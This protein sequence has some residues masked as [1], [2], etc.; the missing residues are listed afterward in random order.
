MWHTFFCYLCPASI[1]EVTA[2][3]KRCHYPFILRG[4]SRWP[5]CTWVGI[6]LLLLLTACRKEVDSDVPIGHFPAAAICDSLYQ[7]GRNHQ[8]LK[9]Y[10]QAIDCFRRCLSV[11]AAALDSLELV[12]LQKPLT[13]AMV[14]LV[15]TYQT[16][17]HPEAC[18]AYLD[19]L[20]VSSSPVI[21]A[22]FLRD[23]LSV[24]AYALSRT[25]RMDEAEQYVTRALQ[26][27]LWHPSE[28]RLFRDYA[29]AAAVY[30][31]NP[32][33]EEEVILYCRQA[34]ELAQFSHNLSGQQYVLS[35]LGTLFKRTGRI[36]EAID[37]LEQSIEVSRR[38]DDPLGEINAYNALTELLLYW[39][40]PQQAD[41]FASRGVVLARNLQRQVHR[42]ANPVILGQLY[43]GK[44]MVK[45]EMQ[46]YDSAFYYYRLSE[47]QVSELPYNSG[48]A[49]VDLSIGEM[50]GD[51]PQ[52]TLL[53]EGRFRLQRAATE[54]T[55]RTRAQAYYQLARLAFAQEDSR[56]AECC[57]DSMYLLLH[58]SHSPYYISG[59]Y[60]LA[61]SHYL[62]TNNIPMIMHYAA[63]CLDEADFNTR[64]ENV[65]KV[66]DILVRQQTDM[67]EAQLQ[68]VRE[69]LRTKTVLYISIIGLIA[70]L[71][72]IVSIVF[73][74]KRRLYRERQKLVEVKMN[75]LLSEHQETIAHLAA[76]NKQSDEIQRRLDGVLS[77]TQRRS[78]LEATSLLDVKSEGNMSQFEYR[79]GL[80]YPSFLPNLRKAVPDI[81]EREIL[82]C[83]LLVM[84]Q[85]SYQISQLMD[86]TPRTVNMMRWRL[87]KKFHLASSQDSLDEAVL[88][89]L[90]PSER[91]RDGQN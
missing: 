90:N 72:V 55:I 9:E 63:A 51:Q 50:L 10:P 16:A 86:V 13:N 17:G 1:N 60:Q 42:P 19:S 15:N 64:Q 75:H 32:V 79:F 59:A 6:V 33:R 31:S 70:L 7:V 21:D 2:K 26:L 37:L 25:E 74:S 87:R 67:K 62:K 49:D 73:F 44:G 57:L 18:A 29:Y 38:C 68:L 81:T 20:S 30:F 58:E 24:T 78:G 82:F 47:A 80:L 91:A 8:R 88:S 34:L 85:S 35:M 76:A 61:L 77:D 83:M 53:Q 43:L 71:L 39:K 54:G 40:L 28:E 11:R 3:M 12:A 52:D 56:R 41:N 27:P 48:L 66:T 36:D 89:L 23:L 22:R 45:Q 69:Q 46:E 14:Q 4:E 84:R 5:V 65:H